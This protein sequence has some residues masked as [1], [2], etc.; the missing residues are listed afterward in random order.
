V[1]IRESGVV[2]ILIGR[3]EVEDNTISGS[4]EPL[5]QEFGDVFL[6]ELPENLPPLRDIQHQI[7]LVPGANLP[8]KP[9]YR[10]S[11]KEH[12]E[13]RRQVEE[14]LAKGHIRESLSPYK[15][16]ALLTPKKDGT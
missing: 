4:V 6:V 13:L 3:M 12:E 7:D 14:L 11:P 8:N 1:E 2:Y 5:L 16:P 15:V 9:H 10:M